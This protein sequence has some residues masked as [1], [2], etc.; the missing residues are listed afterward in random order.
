MKSAQIAHQ[1]RETTANASH[2]LRRCHLAE[3]IYLHQ[4]Y[5]IMQLHLFHRLL[6]STHVSSRVFAFPW[7]P[8]L[9]ARPASRC[10]FLPA[11]PAASAPAISRPW[12]AP[13]TLAAGRLI[14]GNNPRLVYSRGDARLYVGETGLYPSLAFTSPAIGAASRLSHAH[15]HAAALRSY[16]RDCGAPRT[17]KVRSSTATRARQRSKARCRHLPIRAMT[18][19]AGTT[20]PASASRRAAAPPPS[21]GCAPGSPDRRCLTRCSTCGCPAT[22]RS[23]IWT[24]SR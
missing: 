20:Q 17:T 4:V 22:P 14:M 23:Y 7:L 9:S 6:G 13:L 15:R 12:P 18:T 21:C 24:A 19:G 2:L 11:T 8:R 1:R 16:S 3:P 10:R 5:F